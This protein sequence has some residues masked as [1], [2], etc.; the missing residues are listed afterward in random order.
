MSCSPAVSS[1]FTVW[2]FHHIQAWHTY[3]S[4]TAW[5]RMKH[6][7]DCHANVPLT[8]ATVPWPFVCRQHFQA[9]KVK[10]WFMGALHVKSTFL[11]RGGKRRLLIQSFAVSLLEAYSHGLLLLL[12]PHSFPPKGE[13]SSV[14]VRQHFQGGQLTFLKRK[15]EDTL[16]W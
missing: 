15:L 12:S 2:K 6:C 3:S 16:Q 11:Q 7:R 10:I 8:P 4:F 9:L 1:T 14:T 13:P 5:S